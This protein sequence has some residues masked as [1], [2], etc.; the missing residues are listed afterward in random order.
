MASDLFGYS[1]IEDR[2]LL[3]KDGDVRYLGK[4]FTN[5]EVED[6]AS[7]LFKEIEWQND[8][9]V[10]FGKLIVTQRLVAWYAD[11]PYS[12]SYSGTTKTALPWTPLLRDINQRIS[13]ACHE[14][15]NSCLLNLYPSGADGM[16][17]HSDAERELKKDGTIASLS[18]GAERRF[19][20]KHKTTKEM[21][22]VFLESGSLL[23]MQG[24]TQ[25]HWLH[26]LPKTPQLKA[27]RINLT[28]RQ[29]NAKI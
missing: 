21:V 6:L 2:N 27:P 7:Q 16:A 10:V 14:S 25:S 18:F 4:I 5:S 15:F 11:E 26:R 3:P 23:V 29:I 20:F 22:T 12:Y 24:V 19:Q 8:K 13:E 17:W 9:A 1:Q 28:F